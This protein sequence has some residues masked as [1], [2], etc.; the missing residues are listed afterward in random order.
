MLPRG[1]AARLLKRDE[2]GGKRVRNAWQC[3]HATSQRRS[4]SLRLWLVSS[5]GGLTPHGFDVRITWI[6]PEVFWLE[7][8]DAL[9]Q[10]C[11]WH[12]RREQG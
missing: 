2:Q 9:K 12:A 6:E 5:S 4:E 11:R 7:L 1:V 8:D 3:E 10:V